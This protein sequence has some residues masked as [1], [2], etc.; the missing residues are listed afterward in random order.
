[1]I[2]M[3]SFTPGTQTEYNVIRKKDLITGAVFNPK[4]DHC[5]CGSPIKLKYG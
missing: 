4:K 2:E 3:F 1:M 5:G